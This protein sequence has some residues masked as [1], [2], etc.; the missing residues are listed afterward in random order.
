MMH[1]FGHRME[2]VMHDD[3]EAVRDFTEITKP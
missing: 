3:Q 1:A 2:L